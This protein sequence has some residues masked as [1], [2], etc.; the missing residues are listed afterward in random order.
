MAPVPIPNGI[1]KTYRMIK[2]VNHIIAVIPAYGVIFL[3][4]LM[5]LIGLSSSEYLSKNAR[6]TTKYAMIGVN[7]HATHSEAL[8][9]ICANSAVIPAFMNTG[10][11]TPLKIA[12]AEIGDGSIK[13]TTMQSKK[14]MMMSGIPVMLEFVIKSPIRA[15]MTG[16]M[17]VA[18]KMAINIDAK[19]IKTNAFPMS[20]RECPRKEHT[21]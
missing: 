5:R 1:P 19:K 11:N 16:P 6:Y 9:T 10:T 7:P 8:K 2:T 14:L 21:S 3:I 17:F 18:L 20:S 12:Q 4:E 13:L 15:V